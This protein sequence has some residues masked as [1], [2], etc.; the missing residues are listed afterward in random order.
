MGPLPP[1]ED[2]GLVL[3]LLCLAKELVLEELAYRC[4]H[5]PMIGH[6]AIPSYVPDL[7]YPIKRGGVCENISSRRSAEFGQNLGQIVS[8][9]F[10]ESLDSTFMYIHIPPKF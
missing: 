7:A 8:P 10:Q 9:P 6:N 3:A 1:Q 5:P 2:P 4:P